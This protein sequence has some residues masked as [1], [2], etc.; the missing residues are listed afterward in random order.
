MAYGRSPIAPYY[1]TTIAK[2]RAEEELMEK[3]IKAQKEEAAAD[4]WSKLGMGVLD[5]GARFGMMAYDDHLQ[6]TREMEKKVGT[7]ESALAYLDSKV[8]KAPEK[9]IGPPPSMTP[10]GQVDEPVRFI[11]SQGLEPTTAKGPSEMRLARKKAEAKERADAVRQRDRLLDTTKAAKKRPYV[12]IPRRKDGSIDETAYRW[13][14]SGSKPDVAK[15]ASDLKKARK[16][17]ESRDMEEA[18]ESALSALKNAPNDQQRYKAAWTLSKTATYVAKH[19]K[20]AYDPSDKGDEPESPGDREKRV[21]AMALAWKSALETERV[22]Q[23]KRHATNFKQRMKTIAGYI[24]E[25]DF[26]DEE[27]DSIKELAKSKSY[28]ELYSVAT[29]LT[30]PTEVIERPAA[31][32][33][34]TERPAAPKESVAVSDMEK[35]DPRVTE[36]PSRADSKVLLW[37]KQMRAYLNNVPGVENPGQMPKVT[38]Q[39]QAKDGFLQIDGSRLSAAE[40]RRR[41]PNDDDLYKAIYSAKVLEENQL[42]TDLKKVQIEGLVHSKRMAEANLL[43]RAEELKQKVFATQIS[44]AQ[45]ETAYANRVVMPA[46]Q[47]NQGPLVGKGNKRR[48]LPPKPQHRFVLTG[49][50]PVFKKYPNVTLP[51]AV[52][53]NKNKGKPKGG[54]GSKPRTKD[55]SKWDNT[56]TTDQ[57]GYVST[58]QTSESKAA[59]ARHQGNINTVKDVQGIISR[60]TR[61]KNPHRLSDK[62]L[63]RARA[64]AAPLLDGSIKPGTVSWVRQTKA[65]GKLVNDDNKEQIRKTPKV[66][67]SEEKENLKAQR[68]A[69]GKLREIRSQFLGQIAK[70]KPKEKIWGSR[71]DKITIEY[72]KDGRQRNITLSES[73]LS[74]YYSNEKFPKFEGAGG[75]EKTKKARSILIAGRS[76]LK[77]QKESIRSQ[78]VSKI[79]VPYKNYYLRDSATNSE[80]INFLND[81]KLRKAPSPE[82]RASYDKGGPVISDGYLTDKQGSPYAKVHKGEYVMPKGDSDMGL[83]PEQSLWLKWERQDLSKKKKQMGFARDLRLLRK[84]RDSSPR[85]SA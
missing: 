18:T 16:Q 56:P 76:K 7:K 84:T 44:F 81:G 74:Q 55:T 14:N 57:P 50:H 54:T 1:L 24:K 37:R 31:P 79:T 61:S 36:P 85:G 11:A 29:Q 33:E 23:T 82:P 58:T 78:F 20:E 72:K 35:S 8:D 34:V 5:I 2:A 45:A 27:V 28:D 70:I 13:A 46:H 73:E 80:L 68:N 77:K 69:E 21:H 83:N 52:D 67:G 59:G 43:M 64:I 6:R 47:H 65:L 10:R 25:Q 38:S 9:P 19:T 42:D 51:S 39:T 3:R 12:P 53:M 48:H 49:S 4:R 41:Y 17:Y 22:I 63:S 40:M 30:F 26:T 66:G 60:A 32:T 71:A 62:G 15:F 75:A